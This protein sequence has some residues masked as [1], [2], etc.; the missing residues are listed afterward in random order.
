MRTTLDI[1]DDVHAVARSIAGSAKK[2]VGAVV[3]EFAR[4]AIR[5]GA[6]YKA[7][8]FE[9]ESDLDRQLNQLG[10]VPFA[11]GEGAQVTSETVKANRDDEGV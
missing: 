9:S 3:S 4:Q 7:V 8:G 10:L 6:A 5:Q 2:S 11:R 1:D